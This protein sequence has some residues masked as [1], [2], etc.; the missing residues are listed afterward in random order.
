[1][2][3]D[4]PNAVSLDAVLPEVYDTLRAM[5]SRL[6]RSRTPDVSV[7]PTMLVHEVY[8]K[9]ARDAERTWSGKAHF[10]AVAARAMRQVLA[11]RA[12]RRTA[13]KRGGVQSRVTLTGVGVNDD[14]VDLIALDAALAELETLDPRRAQV[15]VLRA[16][17]GLSVDEVADVSG[18]SPR[19]VKTDWRIA[20]A[21]LT[22]RLTEGGVE[23]DTAVGDE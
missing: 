9:L 3:A 2:R 6:W 17:G 11:D 4:E 20:R 15:F 16:M 7:Q 12:R 5:A 18:T 19:T 8:L 21:W 10:T 23:L 1:M 14:P 22:A 13:L